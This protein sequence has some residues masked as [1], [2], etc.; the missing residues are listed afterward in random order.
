MSHTSYAVFGAL[1]VSLTLGAAQLAAGQDLGS[2]DLAADRI[3]VPGATDGVNRIAKSDRGAIA[4]S[5][6]A[7][8]ETIALRFDELADTSVLIRLPL[9]QESREMPAEPTPT[10][11]ARLKLM[12]GCE[13][14][15]SV[16]V[17][18]AKHLQPGRCV[19]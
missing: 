6:S 7:P 19:T 16:L 11:P 5:A 1:A 17:D 12:V 13:P 18:I 2:H 4:A 3:S 9:R 14:T 10:K 8:T 15:V